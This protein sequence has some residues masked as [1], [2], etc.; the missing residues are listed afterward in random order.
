MAGAAIA[1][2]EPGAAP[3]PRE[4]VSAVW[5]VTQAQFETFVRNAPMMASLTAID[6]R[7]VFANHAFATFT[8]QNE[9]KI[10]GRTIAELYPNEHSEEIVA[11]DRTVIETRRA[12]Q[13][14]MTIPQADGPRTV[15]VVKFPVF[16]EADASCWSASIVTDITDQK[17]AETSSRRRS[18][19]RRSAS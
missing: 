9:E 18:A 8:G 14:E 19:W 4:D 11:Q 13:W 2:I 6:G 7:F 5:R 1:A 17:R 15:L 12:G 10:L 3:S 16:D